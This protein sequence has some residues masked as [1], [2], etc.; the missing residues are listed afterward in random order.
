MDTKISLKDTSD[1]SFS[2]FYKYV[3]W[4]YFLF[5]SFLAF[6]VVC[7]TLALVVVYLELFGWDEES[8]FLA[9]F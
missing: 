3:H 4:S 7:V 9:L 6:E 1:S 2:S 5:V 8:A